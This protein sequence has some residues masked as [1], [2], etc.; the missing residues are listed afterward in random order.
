M[1]EIMGAN[2]GKKSWSF[3]GSSRDERNHGSPIGM[4]EIMEANGV[5]EIMGVQ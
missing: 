1:K 5:K 4:K 2:A 3:M